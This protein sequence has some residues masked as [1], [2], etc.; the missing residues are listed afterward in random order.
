MSR[1]VGVTID[2]DADLTETALF[3]AQQGSL[4]VA[5]RFYE[6]VQRTFE[7]LAETPRIGRRW[8]LRGRDVRSRPVVGFENWLVFYRSV[9]EGIEILRVLHG[10]RD[11]RR[12][13]GEVGE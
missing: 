6:R 5:L 13:M 3:L 4:D 2:A 1:R 12:L 9:P 8:K 11:L 7:T 10:A